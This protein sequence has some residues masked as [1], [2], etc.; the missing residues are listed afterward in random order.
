[1]IISPD[2]TLLECFYH[3]EATTPD[4]IYL[5][6]P[7][8]DNFVDFTWKEAGRQARSLAAYLKSLNLPAK[9]SIGLVSK[10]CAEWLIADFAIMMA[11][12]ISVPFYA[13]LT[14]SQINQ[15]LTHS[16]CEVLFVGKLDDWA[17]MKSGIPS[18]VKCISFPTYN[19]DASH[20][21]W[22]DI[23]A[24]YAPITENYIPS[25]N[26]IFTIIYTSGTTGNPKGVMLNYGAMASVIYYARDIARL[27]VQNA[28]FFSYLP[29]CHIAERNIIEAAAVTMGATIYFAET[30][31][32]F[33]KNLASAQP[34]HFL[35]VPRIWTKFQL[36]IL[37]KMPENKLNTLL[38]IPIISSLV[39]KKIQKGLGLH[40]AEIILTG[41]APMPAS[42][43]KWFRR[44]GIII[45]EAYG[46]TENVGAVC[47]MPRDNIKDGS[48]GKIYPGMEVRIAEGTGEI[49][50]RSSW[51]MNGYYKE[52]ELTAETIDAEGWIHTGDV[53]EL[54]EDNYLKITGRVKEM[55]KTSKGEYIAPAQIEFGFADNNFIEQICVVGNNLPQPIGLIVLSDLGKATDKQVVR[56]S[57]EVT[58]KELNPKLKNYERVQR[59]VVL[60]E[61]W[62]VENNKMTPTLKIKRNVIEKEYATK[63]ETWYS[64]SD[65]V[66]WE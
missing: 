37:G 30:L 59:L 15:V 17:G 7:F 43:I 44:L 20:V 49:L 25:V 6:Q 23:L 56:E 65:A 29:L 62:T 63:V 35:A 66:V 41:A 40:K 36:G 27:D 28:R 19:P 16:G 34:T 32:S 61:P 31:D 58:L 11:G 54:D 53:G 14:D 51:N 5:R 46:M 21:Q 39:K 12:H 22:N 48:V 52:P 47:M 18:H 33:A 26:D 3:W 10:N 13:T 57:L 45:Q 60:R 38:K 55:Y 42:L 9:S 4:N 1:M 64:K 50:T 2:K 8:G 24:N